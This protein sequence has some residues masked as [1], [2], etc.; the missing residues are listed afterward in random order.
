MTGFLPVQRVKAMVQSFNQNQ[1]DT[2]RAELQEME[3]T[4]EKNLGSE[5]LP[6]L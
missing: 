5:L 1:L 2:A 4:M 6:L 3:K